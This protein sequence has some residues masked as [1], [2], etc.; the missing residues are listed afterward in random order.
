MVTVAFL[1]NHGSPVSFPTKASCR[2]L[3]QCCKQSPGLS[4]STP[5]TNAVVKD[6]RVGKEYLARLETM[7]SRKSLNQPAVGTHTRLRSNCGGLPVAD[8]CFVHTS[9]LRYEERPMSSFDMCHVQNM[10]SRG[11]GSSISIT[12]SL[13]WPL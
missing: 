3:L 10:V 1:G 8:I 13:Y 6:G 11:L 5:V 7:L 9:A 2:R 12:G 4:V